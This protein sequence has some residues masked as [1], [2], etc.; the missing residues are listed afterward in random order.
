LLDGDLLLNGNTL[1][2]GPAAILSETPGNTVTGTTG[3]ISTIRDL[4]APAGDNVGGLGAMLTSSVNLG[5]TLIERIHSFAVGN[6][7]Q[8]IYRQ[9]NIEPTN[10]TSLNA[11]LRFYY[12][13][14]ELNNIAEAN[15]VLFNSATGNDNTWS[16]AGGTVNTT[17]NY[18]ELSG[19]NNFSHWT[20]GD[21]NSP[22]PVELTSFTAN[23]SENGVVLN[24]K[25]ATETNNSGWNV[26]RQQ[27]IEGQQPTW[28]RIGFVDGSGSSTSSKEYCFKDNNLSSG[29]YQYRLQQVDYDGTLNYSDVIEVESNL[30]PDEFALYQNYPN[31]FNPSTIIKF[32]V[33][34]SSFVNI[35]IYNTIG[36]R[37]ATLVN[38]QM[39]AGVHFTRFDASNMPSG[40]YIYRLT[41]GNIVF[42]NKM[43]LIK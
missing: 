18:V 12:D 4:N 33:P 20:L 37:I 22:I 31:P 35:S 6:G 32:D 1:T 28:Q 10:N 27:I 36:E 41:A 11:T 43:M 25:T 14:S 17:N 13:E 26:Q 8:G 15:L 16:G 5:S 23:V 21:S 9:F 3:K 40:I 42:T 7:N 38:K 29:K 19:I 39:E 34:S 2:L 30:L 24:W